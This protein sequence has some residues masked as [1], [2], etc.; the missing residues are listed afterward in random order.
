MRP[1]VGSSF[2]VSPYE[3][4]LP[5]IQLQTFKLTF[6]FRYISIL[7][8]Q[9]C[10]SRYHGQW[11][12]EAPRS[13]DGGICASLRQATGNALAFAVQKRWDLRVED[14]QPRIYCASLFMRY[15]IE[16]NQL[17]PVSRFI[18]RLNSWKAFPDHRSLY[19]WTCRPRIPHPGAYHNPINLDSK[20][21]R[22]F[23]ALLFPAGYG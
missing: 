21:R 1:P 8:R 20:K 18:R 10:S 9:S 22:S 4:L 12:G 11:C 23:V 17:L 7:P 2:S 15:S 13:P 19:L 3:C 14:F 5:Q 16:T 6:Y